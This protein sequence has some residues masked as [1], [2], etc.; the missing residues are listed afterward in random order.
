VDIRFPAMG[1]RV[2]AAQAFLRKHWLRLLRI[3][4]RLRISEETFHLLLA[5]I[6]GVI[7]GMVN[8]IFHYSVQWTTTLTL[9]A[10]G[11]LVEMA[12]HLDHWQRFL[13]PAI[14]GM[15][16]GLM[17]YLGLRLVGPQGPSHIVEVVVAGDGRLR[18]RSALV[19]AI[20]SL[21]SISTGASIG[22]EGAITQLTATLASK[23]GQ[24]AGWQPYRLRLLVACGAASGIAATYNA[25]VAGAVFAAQVVLGNFAMNMFAPLVF[26]SVVATMVSRSFFGLEPDIGN[27]CP[28]VCSRTNEHKNER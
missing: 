21:I 23:G 13:V 3:R 16:A 22:R 18:L 28:G 14:G 17:L 4:E 1:Q 10:S 24:L 25:P 26:A 8:L 7:G 19:K 20:S 12:R 9:G 27:K 2:S 15:A 5:G 11:E 6:V